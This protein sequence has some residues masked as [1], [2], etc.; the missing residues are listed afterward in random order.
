MN[1]NKFTKV[2]FNPVFTS[3]VVTLATVR[4]AFKTFKLPKFSV[5]TPFDFGKI[6]SK[7]IALTLV[8]VAVL[9]VGVILALSQFGQ[10]STFEQDVTA[11]VPIG[12]SFKFPVYGENGQATDISLTMNLTTA[13]KMRNILIQGK[14]AQAREGKIFLIVNMEVL[15]DFNQQLK[16]APVDL[17]RLVDATGKKFAPDVHNEDVIV[18]PISVKKTRVGFVVDDPTTGLELQ[19]GEIDGAKETVNLAI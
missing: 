2:K 7:K 10:N 13:A 17:I 15:N 8:I 12:R 14:P 6:P 9:A 1:G 11:E 16:I 19:V 5:R 3:S 4:S 18:E